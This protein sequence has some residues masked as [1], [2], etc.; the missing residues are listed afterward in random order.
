MPGGELVIGSRV[1]IG[2]GVNI[3]SRSRIEIGDDVRL[4]DYVSIVDTDFH[5]ARDRNAQPQVAPI[6]VGARSTIG[7]HATLLRGARLGEDVEVAPG[8]LVIGP[9]PA[10]ARIAGVPAKVV[11]SAGAETTLGRGPASAKGVAR[12]AKGA[13]ARR[14]SS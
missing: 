8:S 4:A 13:T 7:V 12:L 11:T 6:F 3:S 1:Y 2:Q 10:G 5:S 9:V 14:R